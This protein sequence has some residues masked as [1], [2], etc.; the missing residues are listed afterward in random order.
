MKIF[1]DIKLLEE[2]SKIIVDLLEDENIIKNAEKE[3]HL[4]DNIPTKKTTES[5]AIEDNFKVEVN[6]KVSP[7]SI[8]I[9][10]TRILDENV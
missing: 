1:D 9:L 8:L 3:L 2:F 7:K 5:T 6:N 4:L 10:S